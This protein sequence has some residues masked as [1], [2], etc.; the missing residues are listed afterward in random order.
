MTTSRKIHGM[1][2]ILQ[3]FNFQSETKNIYKNIYESTPYP[4]LTKRIPQNS[5][6]WNETRQEKLFK[7]SQSKV[8]EKI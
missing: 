3:Y 4:I 1:N 8:H 2:N 5:P 7:V 6:R